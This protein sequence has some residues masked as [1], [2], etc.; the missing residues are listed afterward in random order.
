[1]EQMFTLGADQARSK[2]GATNQMFYRRIETPSAQIPGKEEGRRNSENE[3][4]QGRTSQ[5]L[6]LPAPGGFKEGTTASSMELDL[7]RVRGA[8]GE[9]QVQQGIKKDLCPTLQADFRW[10][11]VHIYEKYEWKW[12]E[13]DRC[14]EQKEMRNS[15]G[16]DPKTFEENSQGGGFRTLEANSQGEDPRTFKDPVERW[17]V[18]EKQKEEKWKRKKKKK[19]KKKKVK[20]RRRSWWNKCKERIAR[21][22]TA[23]RK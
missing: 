6:V 17:R 20:Y 21:F 22:L 1:M 9:F 14:F 23:E 8:H 11:E 19:V 5:Q 4:E 12:D 7:P 15:Q 10:K 3:Q 13:R 16:K 18:Q 2:F